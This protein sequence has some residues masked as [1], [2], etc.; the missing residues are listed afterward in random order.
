[1]K[2]IIKKFTNKISAALI[3]TST[4]AITPIQSAK[5]AEIS[6]LINT[7]ISVYN[8]MLAV[9]ADAAYQ[10][11]PQIDIAMNNNKDILNTNINS[12]M[13]DYVDL[14]TSNAFAGIR[15][16]N[17]KDTLAANIKAGDDVDLNIKDISLFGGID[18][19]SKQIKDAESQKNN[20]MF[21]VEYLLG[22]NVYSD[23]TAKNNAIAY[24]EQIKSISPPPPVIRIGATFDVPIMNMSDPNQKTATVGQKTPLT[25]KDLD[26]LRKDLQSDPIYRSYKKAYRSIVALR[27]LFL[28]NLHYSYQIRVPQSNG[29]S[30]E[31]MKDEQ[32]ASRLTPDYYQ[33]MSTASPDTVGRET[34]FVLAEI[35]N[36]LNEIRK[37]NERIIVMT[38]VNSLNQIAITVQ[39]LNA[40]AQQIGQLVYCK[41]PGNEEDPLCTQQSSST[42]SM[43]QLTP[44]SAPATTTNQ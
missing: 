27:N 34:L 18:E 8:N 20:Y 43:E 36:E 44:T 7:V 41:A 14:E 35:R 31:Q 22:P 19:L 15:A 33:K 32:A 30:I 39:N 5:A 6:D 21:N 24:L 2:K 13:K 23:T 26:K 10:F 42:I 12:A 37:Q 1:M 28:D 38:S 25:S 3:I 40:N 4:L 9:Y 11:D 29:K 16:Q 17:K